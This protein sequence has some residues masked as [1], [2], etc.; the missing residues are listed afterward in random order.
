[1]HLK[2]SRRREF[3][4]E[5]I[6]FVR[7]SHQQTHKLLFRKTPNATNTVLKEAI[8]L[9]VVFNQESLLTKLAS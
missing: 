3:F 4:L 8:G 6:F 2:E 5:F 9:D 1:M 7:H